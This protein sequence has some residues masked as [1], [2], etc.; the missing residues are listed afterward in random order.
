MKRK[1]TKAEFDALS[2]VL[3]KLYEESDGIYVLMLEDDDEDVA[4]LTTALTASRSDT[5]KEKTARTRLEAQ[6]AELSA[7][8]E[9]L[10]GE[11]SPVNKDVKSIEASYKQK[12]ADEKR[13]ADE[14]HASLRGYIERTTL[15]KAAMELAA[16]I[17]TVPKVMVHHIKSRLKIEFDDDEPILRVL[18][19]AGNPSALSLVDLRKELVADKELSG[20]VKAS[21]GRG[22][23]ASGNRRGG[24]AA[25]TLD[26]MTET[27]RTAFAREDPD[28]FDAALA[29]QRA[30][31]AKERN[32]RGPA[33]RAM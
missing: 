16:E 24:G 27:E 5:K 28:G 23:G 21:E 14:K 20:I 10:T 18:D 33:R 17:S 7:K 9:E 32:K 13:T 26:D 25:K 2:D 8:V 30:A 11:P 1:L 4:R 12:L 3:K 19:S 6:V 22:G 29:A 15:D 31:F